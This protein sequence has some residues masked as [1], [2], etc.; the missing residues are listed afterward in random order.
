MF[1]QEIHQR[2]IFYR[3]DAVADTLGAQFA[4][5]LPD[6]FRPG[7]FAGMHGDAQAS[8]ARTVKVAEEQAAG[9]AELVASQIQRG[10]AVAVCQQTFQLFQTGIFAKGAA[11]DANQ[12]HVNAAIAAAATHAVNHR[13]H[14]A[15]NRQAMLHCHV[16][17]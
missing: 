10:D 15:G 16:I 13:F 14:H 3:L 6:A 9:E 11:H 2:R 7:G 12:A 8:V 5:R 4:N 1:C 17:R